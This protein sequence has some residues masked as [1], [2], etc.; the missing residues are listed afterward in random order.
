M[1]QT[2]DKSA[3]LKHET[4]SKT[5]LETIFQMRKKVSLL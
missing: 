1:T 5:F 3:F 2:R 4:I